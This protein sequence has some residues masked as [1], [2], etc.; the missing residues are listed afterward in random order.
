[1][2]RPLFLLGQVMSE[3]I[4]TQVSKSNFVKT[5]LMMMK[6]AFLGARAPLGLAHVKRNQWKSWEIVITCSISLPLAFRI[7]GCFKEVVT[8][9]LGISRVFQGCY[10]SVTRV[11][12]RCYMGVSGV[13]NGCF[14]DIS[15][16]LQGCYKDVK[17]VFK[18]CQIGVKR[19]LKGCYKGVTR[20]LQGCFNGC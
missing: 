12:Q 10:T 18:R 2:P 13:L 6:V 1:M 5:V 17:R 15:R 4:I 8:N 20:V 16:I 9:I 3:E 7:N 11:L 19:V 14:K